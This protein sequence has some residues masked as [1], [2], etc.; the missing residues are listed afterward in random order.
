M[1]YH[2]GTSKSQS[3]SVYRSSF[4]AACFHKL[5]QQPSPS[6][7]SLPWPLPSTTKSCP[8]YL[9][10]VHSI[11]AHL[12]LSLQT[13]SPS[14]RHYLPGLLKKPSDWATFTPSGASPTYSPAKSRETAFKPEIWSCLQHPFPSLPP[15]A[16][17]MEILASFFHSFPYGLPLSLLL[18][19]LLGRCSPLTWELPH[20]HF[21]SHAPLR[22][23]SM[24][25]SLQ[26]TTGDLRCL[27]A[28]P[29]SPGPVQPS[30]GFRLYDQQH[31]CFCL[32]QQL[33]GSPRRV[34][35]PLSL[36]R[37]QDRSRNAI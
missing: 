28:C 14:Y 6:E 3:F 37:A 10:G 27:V 21:H 7:P 34:L 2:V 12:F 26:D 18:T 30:P 25:N 11:Q 32:S 35:V 24:R 15:S 4:R 33:A 23:Q 36:P 8:P 22:I 19:H 29:G 5:L 20:A 16:P 17:R 13:L 31:H 9:P 1:K